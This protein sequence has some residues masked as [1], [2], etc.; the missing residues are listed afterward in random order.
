VN[1]RRQPPHNVRVL[2]R[3]LTEVEAGT[4][5]AVAR[6][7]RWVSFMVVAAMLDQVRDE[8]DQPMFLL[9]DGVALELRLGLHARAT[10]DY[11]A[12]FHSEM[13][14]LVDLILMWGLVDEAAQSVDQIVDEIQAA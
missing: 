3:W 4:G 10:R 11:D 12:A 2:Q 9:K 8:H 1:G 5:V 14:N 13:S 7:Q 6:Q